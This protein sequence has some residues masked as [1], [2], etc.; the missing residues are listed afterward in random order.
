MSVSVDAEDCAMSSIQKQDEP[1]EKG[2]VRK[3][4]NDICHS[5]GLKQQGFETEDHSLYLDDLGRMN[6]FKD[7]KLGLNETLPAEFRQNAAK[8]VRQSSIVQQCEEG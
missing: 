3:T 6:Y 5:S 7:M 2:V 1:Y 8:I 4:C